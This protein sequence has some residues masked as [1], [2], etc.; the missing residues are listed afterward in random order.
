MKGEIMKRVYRREPGA[1]VTAQQRQRLETLAKMPDSEIDMSDASPL[2][3]SAW[4]EAVRGRFYRPLKKAVSLRLD[5]DLIAWL[6][7][8]GEGYQTRANKMLRELMVADLEEGSL[9]R[10]IETKNPPALQTSNDPTLDISGMMSTPRNVNSY[11]SH[12]NPEQTELV[13]AVSGG[14]I[15]MQRGNREAFS[16]SY[17]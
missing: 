7:K 8:D 3:D 6:K 16:H 1:P 12:L 2:P 17:C 4:K 15:S 5:A 11:G 13:N 14:V 10:E 9:K